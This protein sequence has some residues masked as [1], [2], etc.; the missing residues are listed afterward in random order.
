[1]GHH[2]KL[3]NTVPW[4]TRLPVHELGKGKVALMDNIKEYRGKNNPWK[5]NM[6]WDKDNLPTTISNI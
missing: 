5:S 1:M 6:A 3:K 2:L 4:N